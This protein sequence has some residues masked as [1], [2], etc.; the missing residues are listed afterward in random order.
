LERETGLPAVHDP[1]RAAGAARQMREYFAGTRVAFDLPLAPHGS[2][3]QRAVWDTLM[4]IPP[5]E[6]RSYGWVAARIGRPSASR[7]VGAAN[8][9]NPIVI[10]VPCH[11][12]V[13]A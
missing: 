7:A 5:G 4:D 8:G 3:F 10:V 1:E 13:G 6:T 9:Q 12:V 11:R 2:E